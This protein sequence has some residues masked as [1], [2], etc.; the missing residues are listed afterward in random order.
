MVGFA[1]LVFPLFAQVHGG[2]PPHVRAG[3]STIGATAD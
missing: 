2:L 3:R 1:F